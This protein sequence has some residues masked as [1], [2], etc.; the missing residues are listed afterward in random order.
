MLRV[1]HYKEWD[2]ITEKDCA[3]EDKWVNRWQACLKIFVCKTTIPGPAVK[4][5][6]RRK[7]RT[8]NSDNK[9]LRALKFGNL[10]HGRRRSQILYVQRCD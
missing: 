10:S 7:D 3:P 4:T 9:W 6:F 8:E 2:Q 5:G 1:A